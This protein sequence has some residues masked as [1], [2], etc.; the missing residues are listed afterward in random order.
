MESAAEAKEIEQK[1][2]VAPVV[3][4]V[5]GPPRSTTIALQCP[6]ELDGNLIET[7]TVRR[8]TAAEVESFISSVQRGEDVELP[9]VD[10]PAAVLDQ[11]DHDDFMAVNSAIH[12]H[13][14]AALRQEPRDQQ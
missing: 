11:L 8:L 2:K 6:F 10:L 13:F 9:M 4:F 12:R 5:G 1:A 7:V 14:P 3:K